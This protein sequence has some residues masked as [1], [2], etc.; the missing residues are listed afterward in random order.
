MYDNYSDEGGALYITGTS[1]STFEQGKISYNQASDGAG[2]AIDQGA[3][4]LTNAAV[5]CNTA[6]TDG[7]GIFM[8][9]S[10]SVTLTNVGLYKNASATGVTH[11]V[12]VYVGTSTTLYM[13][14]SVVQEAL[15]AYALYGAGSGTLS[16][17]NV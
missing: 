9:T 8:E 6:V 4:Y 10:G 16:Y 17:N 3:L 12:G 14:N 7:G 13:Y 2:V 5:Y 11:A 15:N 1:S